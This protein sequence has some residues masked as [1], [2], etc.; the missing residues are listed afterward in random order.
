MQVLRITTDKQRQ[1]AVLKADASGFPDVNHR[2]SSLSGLEEAGRVMLT[3]SSV[4]IGAR[5]GVGVLALS[6]VLIGF[7]VAAS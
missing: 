7:L 1:L 3:L 2:A 5:L 6:A 4:L